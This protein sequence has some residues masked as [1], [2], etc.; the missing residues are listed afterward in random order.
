MPTSKVWRG[1]G[2]GL[3][4]VQAT[5]A[6]NRY[7]PPLDYLFFPHSRY[8]LGSV[9]PLAICLTQKPRSR[10]LLSKRRTGGR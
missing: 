2:V 3:T 5:S 6:R 8:G 9:R 10:R 4:V 1:E 7:L